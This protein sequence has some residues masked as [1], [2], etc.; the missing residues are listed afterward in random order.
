MEERKPIGGKPMKPEPGKPI[1]EHEPSNV[2]PAG[3]PTPKRPPTPSSAGADD[4]Q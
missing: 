1:Q 3:D 2:R 4:A